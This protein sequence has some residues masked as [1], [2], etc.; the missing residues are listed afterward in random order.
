MGEAG[1]NQGIEQGI[2]DAVLVR[3]CVRP[4]L[5]VTMLHEQSFVNS[6]AARRLDIGINWCISLH[7]RSASSSWVGTPSSDG[8][9][10]ID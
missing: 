7:R 4:V 3:E 5:P 8:F 9:K 2:A 10:S 6:P 1:H